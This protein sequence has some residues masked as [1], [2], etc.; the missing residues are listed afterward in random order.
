MKH[1]AVSILTLTMMDDYWSKRYDKW[2]YFNFPIVIFH[3]YIYQ[4]S[5]CACT[6][7]IYQLLCA[8]L[9]AL[10]GCGF[11]YNVLHIEVLLFF[12]YTLSCRLLCLPLSVVFSSLY[13]RF[14]SRLRLLFNPMISSTFCL[15][16]AVNNNGFG[17][18]QF[19]SN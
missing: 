14:F 13:W 8:L 1:D 4:C 11:H 12:F 19:Q 7:K 9:I 16:F 5:S 3:S 6:W 10:I 15:I 17:R 2:D 18:K